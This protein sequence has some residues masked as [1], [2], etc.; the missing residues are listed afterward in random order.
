MKIRFVV[1]LFIFLSSLLICIY[2]FG[3]I[4]RQYISTAQLII[5]Q[6]S[7]IGSSVGPAA[8]L[9]L[10]TPDSSLTDSLLIKEY[11]LSREMLQHLHK[12]FDLR[13]I[14]SG[15]NLDVFSKLSL[16]A[17]EEDFL[18]Y[19]NKR[20]TIQYDE[21]SNITHISYRD[22]DPFIS[23]KILEEIIAQSELFI[24]DISK[25]L[26]KRQM[27]FIYL[28]HDKAKANLENAKQKLKQFQDTHTLITPEREAKSISSIISKLESEL[29]QNQIELQNLQVYLSDQSIQII[30]L[31]EKLQYIRGQ[32]RINERKLASINRNNLNDLQMDFEALSLEIKFLT[33]VYKAS[34]LTLEETKVRA[35]KQMKYLIVIEKPNLADESLYPK[36]W[37]W[38]G[39]CIIILLL[40]I[41]TC[42]LIFL[43]LRERVL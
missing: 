21:L 29:I 6:D 19:Y 42:R 30:K 27:E 36:S 20:L 12:K 38:S 40:S 24:N 28:E 4:T 16:R 1:F 18:K 35:I 7:K 15:N 25:Q 34:L 33:D 23:K 17:S 37:Y 26:I 41:G 13:Q 8:S 14:Y 39:T 10:G 31:K 32:I 3:L 22:P 43:T 5:K 9:L 2:Y 11:I